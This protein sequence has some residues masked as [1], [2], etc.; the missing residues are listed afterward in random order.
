VIIPF[1]NWEIT[2]DP[3]KENI[4]WCKTEGTSFEDIPLVPL[5]FGSQLKDSLFG[6]YYSEELIKGYMDNMNLLYVAFTR[7]VEALMICLP[8]SGHNGLKTVGD[9]VISAFAKNP[10]TQPCISGWEDL[11]TGDQF[12]FGTL[13]ATVSV[14]EKGPG[15]WI[16]DKYP[17]SSRD[18]ILKIRLK[19][20]DYFA[21]IGQENAMKI[22]FGKV[23]HDIYADILS[24]EDVGQAVNKA[25]REG[26]LDP[27]M[28]DGVADSI[29]SSLSRKEVLPWFEKQS[30]IINEREILGADGGIY[31]P[32]RIVF[33]HGSVKV[34]DFKFGD[35]M[36]SEYLNQVRNYTGLL[37][38]MGYEEVIGYIW[39]VTLDKIIEVG[40]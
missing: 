40:S 34:I 39:Y 8:A 14:D 17:V 7:A 32:D 33:S 38:S 19:S 18:E 10:D 1:C 28:S 2:T 31:R 13:A 20:Q 36:K 16:M 22:E 29:R 30:R 5:R 6:S 11:F 12:T 4:L 15:E 25:V 24:I 23:M 3:R 27:V 21:E 26:V 9:L 37:K 35:T